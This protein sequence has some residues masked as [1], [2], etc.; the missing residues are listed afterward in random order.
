MAL[1][2]VGTMDDPGQFA[3]PQMAL[4]TIDRQ[5]FHHVPEGSATFERM[6][7]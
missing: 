4:Y 2:E 5:R 1:I 3:G 6:P 7:G